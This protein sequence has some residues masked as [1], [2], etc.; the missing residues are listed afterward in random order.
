MPRYIKFP[1]GM[2]LT[3]RY[4]IALSLPELQSQTNAFS[5]KWAPGCA[6]KLL[7]SDPPNLFLHYNVSCNAKW[8]DPRG[9]EVR[10]K[11][12]LSKVT[13][14]QS[15]KDLDV[16]VSCS[17][18]AMGTMLR[19]ADGTE[20]P[21]ED[22]KVGDWVITHKGRARQ[23]TFVSS[24]PPKD[25]EQAWSLKSKGYQEPLV[26]SADHPSARVR[27]GKFSWGCPPDLVEKES[28][29]FPKFQWDGA[30]TA[31]ADLAALLGYY[32][33]EGHLVKK[34]K[35]GNRK[36]TTAEV[37][38][39]DGDAYSLYEIKYV[40]NRAEKDTL[41]RDVAERASRLM[42]DV[43]LSV[44]DVNS[45]T[46]IR[47]KSP[48][49]AR[50]MFELGG[51]SD[52]KRKRKNFAPAVMA[53][54][55]ASFWEV[56]TAYALGDGHA[57]EFGFDISS[58]SPDIVTQS[59]HFLLSQGVWHGLSRV[60]KNGARRIRFNLR[61]YPELYRR[62]KPLLRSDLPPVERQIRPQE[63]WN[64]GWLRPLLKKVQCVAPTMFHDL[65]VDEDES[66]I[67]NGIVVHNCPAFLYWG[68]QWALN[69]RDS[70]EG[71]ARPLLAP[72]TERLDLRGHFVL[73][74]HAWVVFKR[75]LPSVQHNVDKI[76]RQLEVEKHQPAPQPKPKVKERQEQMKRRQEVQETR[77]QRN[78]QIQQDLGEAAKRRDERLLPEH[79]K[80][81]R[82]EPAT[83]EHEVANEPDIHDP[84]LER[85]DQQEKAE[86]AERDRLQQEEEAKMMQ[87]EDTE[88]DVDSKTK[89][90]ELLDRKKKQ[91]QE[92]GMKSFL[93]RKYR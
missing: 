73:C 74:K 11:F 18:V 7:D 30:Q 6:A 90:R 69:Q 10:V 23:V 68:A 84:E 28:L 5:H 2:L 25:G 62:M 64:E 78:E 20:K 49:F 80:V 76:L 46:E 66:F 89:D 54:D 43:E 12:D 34:R 45:W 79:Y 35:R 26:L 44:K 3:S 48:K 1:L 81:V 72:P 70:L 22:V 37:V 29:Y 13:D 19:M 67:A 57:G 60:K 63:I 53:W 39:I 4:K 38:F 59:S 52:Q 51:F 16:K 86:Q 91:E 58:V 9:H 40:F 36:A 15:A 83:H 47:V 50:L 24:R 88:K 65:T 31:D 55:I 82:T 56:L 85:L 14:E 8:S 32:A 33:A 17:C 27:D 71:Q 42:P 61:A 87:K 77:K 41:V 92:S 75:I 21:I 93:D